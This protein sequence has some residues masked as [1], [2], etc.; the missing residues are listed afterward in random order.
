MLEITTPIVLQEE[1]GGRKF[2]YYKTPTA[3]QTPKQ[4]YVWR[5]ELQAPEGAKK[6]YIDQLP[7]SADVS[8]STYGPACRFLT[9]A[10]PGFTNDA[11]DCKGC[12]QGGPSHYASDRCESGKYN[13]CSCD[14]CF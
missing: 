4:R 12:Q 5:K 7:E 6:V 1:P 14:T 2:F 9:I 13:H 3:L 8:E 11:D 10:L